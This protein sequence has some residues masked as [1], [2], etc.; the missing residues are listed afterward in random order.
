MALQL[1][2]SDP[3]ALAQCSELAQQWG[4]DEVNLNCG[5]PSDRVQNNMIGAVLMGHADLVAQCVSAMQAAVTLPV[6]VKH[7]IGVD[8]MEDYDGL[9]A[10]VDTVASAGCSTFIV[11]ARKAWL[12]G[13]SPKQ[14][15]EIP[16]LRYELVHQ[17][18][19]DRPN[20]EIIINGGLTSLEACAEQLN[21]VDGVMVGREAYHNPAW[22][23]QVD[24]V[25]YH[26]DQAAAD[27]LAVYE[28]YVAYCQQQLSEGV[29]LGTVAKHLLGLFH[30]QRGARLFRRYLSDHIHKPGADTDILWQALE[31]VNGP[32]PAQANTV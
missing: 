9:L 2:G 26:S 28:Q 4:Y 3:L 1:G 6:T 15:R 13:L 25:L 29:R 7:R 12:Q 31:F 16:P 5:C 8:D 20:L 10:F 30:G 21:H 17:L 22:L 27:I 32:A 23:A 19:R 18:K 11:H 14:N 24:P